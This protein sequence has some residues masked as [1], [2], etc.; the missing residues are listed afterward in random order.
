MEANTPD[1]D[2]NTCG[3]FLGLTLTHKRSDLIRAVMEGV[4]FDLNDMLVAMEETNVPKLF[5][6]CITGGIA[7]S[8]LWNQIQAD[9]YNK[10]VVATE[11]E[12]APV[13]GSGI[14][15]IA[16]V[17]TG[18]YKD[19]QEAADNMVRIRKCYHPNPEN[20]KTYEK[21]YQIWRNAFKH[22]SGTVFDQVA[23]FPKDN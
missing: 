8:E 7:R 18:I 2:E 19:Y 1:Y 6:V 22:F 21:L 15:I 14:G 13:L 11:Y 3:T 23:T 17:G 9:I 20:V 12:G 10:E 5:E 4:V 16:A